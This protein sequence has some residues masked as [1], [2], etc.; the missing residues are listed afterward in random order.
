ME[1]ILLGHGSGGRL[2]HELISSVFRKHFIWPELAEAGD[3]GY[4]DIPSGQK[5]AFTTDSFVV[6]PLFFPGGNIG[7]L[8]VCGT[9][10][11]LS[12][13][14][15]RPLFLSA[16]F[17][18]EEGFAVNELE[19]I[20]CSMAETCLQA[21]VAIAAGDTKV[22]EK[23]K[24]DGIF[25]NTSGIGCFEKIYKPM[26]MNNIKAGDKIILS[27]TAGDHG[28]AIMLARSSMQIKSSLASDCAPLA[29]LCRDALS[30]G[31]IRF[32]RDPTR[33]G[34]TAVLCEIA[35]GGKC[36]LEIS[37]ELI[38]LHRE[39]AALAEML[40][41]DPLCMANEGKMVIIASAASAASVLSVLSKNIYGKNCA[42]IGEITEKHPGEVLLN[43]C[44]GGRRLLEM[45]A[46]DQLPRIC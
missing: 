40:G 27:G 4:I 19:K 17:I 44:V 16:G 23:G 3:A 7:K 29:A 8:A 14:G 18:I 6:H 24:A 46:A 9:V 41:F 31:D 36:G 43:T 5:L 10:N 42:I 38:P 12:A 45:P 39:T 25:I 28:M 33:G 13:A 32:M 11:D 15:S 2:T 26:Y 35:M 37:E 1:Q 20:V 22:V 34:L 21:G 30:C